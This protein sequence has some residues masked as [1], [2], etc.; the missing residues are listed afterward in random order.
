[1]T[2]A[3]DAVR[4]QYEE[5]VYPL[6][7]PDIADAID[8]GAFDFCDPS[9][10]RR[11]LWP[12]KVEPDELEILVAGCGSNQ[13][14]FLAYT[15]PGCFI[16]GIDLSAKSLD[17]ERRLKKKHNLANL[18]LR[19]LPIEEIGSFGR[20]F[21]YIVSSGVL[22]HLPDP[23]LGL[24]AL[25]DVL[26]PH[27]VMSV[28]VYGRHGRI[29]VYLLQEL[30]RL[31]GTKQ[32][33]S[34]VELVR[35]VVESL[36]DWHPV[37]RYV[38]VMSDMTYDAGLVDSFLHPVDRAYTVA[39]AARFGP[40]N[41]LAFQG[42]VDR[43][44]YSLSAQLP[45]EDDPLRQQAELLSEQEQWEFVELYLQW[46][47][48]HRFALCHPD[49]PA[50]DYTVDFSGDAWLDYVPHLRPPIDIVFRQRM[51]SASVD[52]DPAVAGAAI[53]RLGFTVE[54]N[55]FG[56]AVLELVDAKTPIRGILEASAHVAQAAGW[57]AR[58]HLEETRAFFERMAG[59]DHLLFEIP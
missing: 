48:V 50:A 2:D 23:D 37:R 24:R 46:P 15:N 47:A 29:G 33:A 30:F 12:R 40:D 8:G 11:K 43:I 32:D 18:E 5:W 22:H 52:D 57:D 17:H 51:M 59:W 56:A 34:G 39:E 13:A 21:D 38:G 53:E 6:P 54:I 44:H 25:R 14:A 3:R 1:M 7:I 19:Q 41:G 36:P 10:I 58:T 27:G 9:L 42:W 31:L 49:R 55:L 45:V 26:E 20:S 28:M 4:A 35:H 16:T